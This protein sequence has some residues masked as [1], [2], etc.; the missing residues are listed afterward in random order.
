MN[1]VYSSSDSYAAVAGVSLYS[2]MVNNSD[3]DELRIFIIDN[4]ISEKNKEKLTSMCRQFGRDVTFIPIADIEKLVGTS[5]DVGRWNISTFARLFYGSL[6]PKSVDKVIHVDCDT[7]VM[8]SLKPLWD[9]DLSG[10]AVAGALECIG[11]SYKTEIGMQKDD[12][13]LNA[14]NVMLN[15][16]YIRENGLEEKFKKFIA[17]RDRLSF[18]DQPVLNA[19]TTNEEKLVVDLRYNLY[20]LVYYLKYKN[21][22]KAKRVSH[23]YTDKEVALAKRNPCIVHFTTCFMDGTRPWIEGNRHPLVD[24]YLEYRAQ[25]P[26]ADEPLWADDRSAVKKLGYTMFNKLPQGFVAGSI[27]TVHDKIIP[28]KNKLK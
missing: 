11:D 9:M 3:C 19:C 18:M 4:H 16:D 22:L 20:A 27:G 7:M 2:L 24:R 14:G 10:K 8:D 26:W 5:I 12:I 25:T 1:I 13:Y 6:L 28:M 15:L 23:Y 17:G 21:V